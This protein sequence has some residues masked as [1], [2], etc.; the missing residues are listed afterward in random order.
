MAVKPAGV[1][2]RPRDIRSWVLA[3]ATPLAILLAAFLVYTASFA[4]FTARTETG[5][6][7]FGTGTVELWND[8]LTEAVFDETNL[9]PGDTSWAMARVENRGTLPMTVKLYSRVDSVGQDLAP[10]VRLSIRLGTG[11][12]WVGTIAEFQALDEYDKGILPTT[13]VPDGEEYLIV[14]YL[15]LDTAPQA[16]EASFVFV[17][18]GR[19]E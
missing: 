3:L 9:A 7:T 5:P 17:W 13:M 12:P 6:N 18:E 10:H 15:V 11:Q 1:E 14:E 4:A 2:R 8:H 19:T 16:A